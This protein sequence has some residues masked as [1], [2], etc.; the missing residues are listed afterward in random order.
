[1]LWK[2]PLSDE[3]A[4]GDAPAEQMLLVIGEALLDE[5]EARQVIVVERDD[6]DLVAQRKRHRDR[7][8]AAGER[9]QSVLSP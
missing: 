7:V 8:L 6:L 9:K 4:H 2:L 3:S 5:L 1:V